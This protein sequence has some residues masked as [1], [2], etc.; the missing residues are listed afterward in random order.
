M[1]PNLIETPMAVNRLAT[2]DEIRAAILPFPDPSRNA[3]QG[4]PARSPRA[5]AGTSAS[6]PWNLRPSALLRK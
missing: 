3:G 5:L 1:K 4:L 2:S 6:L